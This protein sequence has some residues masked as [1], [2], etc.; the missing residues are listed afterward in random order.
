MLN[1]DSPTNNTSADLEKEVINRFRS[2]SNILPRECKVFREPWESSTIL[3]LD[4]QACPDFLDYAQQ[5]K[6]LLLL[7]AINLGLADAVIF[8]I[9]NKFIRLSDEK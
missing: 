3:C 1:Q 5:E 8:R 6:D 4:F 2:L 7:V 9:G